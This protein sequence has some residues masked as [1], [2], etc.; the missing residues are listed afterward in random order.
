MALPWAQTASTLIVQAMHSVTDLL[1]SANLRE[2]LRSSAQAGPFGAVP[3]LVVFWIMWSV[4][5]AVQRIVMIVVA[6]AVKVLGVIVFMLVVVHLA[7]PFFN[8][9][10]G[11]G[12]GAADDV[13]GAPKFQQQYRAAGANGQAS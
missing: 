10:G 13:F 6:T 4:L 11:G 12:P 7:E 3:A 2:V 8:G 1:I 9:A 5:R